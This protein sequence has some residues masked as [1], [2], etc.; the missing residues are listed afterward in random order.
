[1]TYSLP[2]LNYDYADLTPYIDAETMKIHHTKHHQA[3]ISSLNNTVNTNN[4]N[5][6]TLT[7][8]LSD[9]KNNTGI[10][11]PVKTQLIN[12]GGGHFNHSF[13]WKCLSPC[14]SKINNDEILN[15][16]DPKLLE[17]LNETFNNFENFKKEF[18][19]KAI[20]L[21]GS[22]WV[23]LI[24][25]DNKIFIET[26]INQDNPMMEN[27]NVV[28]LLCLDVW[29]HAY[30]L[31]YQNNRALY[32]ENWWSVINWKFVNEI[33]VNVCIEKKKLLV[34]NNGEIVVE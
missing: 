5:V 16:L 4:I 23:W 34:L 25:K 17:K 7:E 10:N 30:Y 15:K 29:E 18:S 20:K 33:F 24:C 11:E 1:M 13:F 31:N 6:S 22:G 8:L 14:K 2:S 3:Y 21:F 12:F 32:V 19:D 26:N 27:G 9:I 28:P